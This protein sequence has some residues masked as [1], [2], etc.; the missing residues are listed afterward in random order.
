MIELNT[1]D[2]SPVKRVT[3]TITVKVEFNVGGEDDD[4]R[5]D[6]VI[7]LFSDHYDEIADN[8]FLRN[9]ITSMQLTEVK[10]EGETTTAFM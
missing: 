2:G 6:S 7:E 3:A 5:V 8:C 4:D 1:M 9:G 10:S